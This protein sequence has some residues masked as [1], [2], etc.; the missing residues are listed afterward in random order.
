[1]KAGSSSRSGR[2]ENKIDV[3]GSDLLDAS[4][5][6]VSIRQGRVDLP[7][8]N[9][10]L[11]QL[12]ALVLHQRNQRRHDDG[13]ARKM[14]RRQLVTEGLAGAG[15]HDRDRV[16]TFDDRLDD[17]LLSGSEFFEPER[18]SHQPFERSNCACHVPVSSMC[19]NNSQLSAISCRRGSG[20][21]LSAHKPQEARTPVQF[22]A[23]GFGLNAES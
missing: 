19:R 15:R 21:M 6:I 11:I 1:M 3:A 5:A 8:D 22:I 14:E 20:H 23:R 7:G 4:P 17:G 2:G 10:K 9:A 12:V 18:T 13:R 16:V